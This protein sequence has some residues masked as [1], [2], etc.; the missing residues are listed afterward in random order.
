MKNSLELYNDILFLN[1]RPWKFD[2]Q[3]DAKFKQLL[4][5]TKKEYYSNQPNYEVDF[6]KPLSNLHKYY[7]A[8]IDH[9]AIRFLNI[10][11]SEISDSL[12]QQE[13]KYNIYVALSKILTPKL[14]EIAKIIKD[15]GYTPEQFDL[16]I[17][18]TSITINIANQSYILHYLK[19]Q[20]IRLFLEV[21]DSF[22]E[23]MNDDSLTMEEVYNSFFNEESPKRPYIIE[24]VDYPTTKKIISK[25]QEE[26]KPPFK[27][28]R[29]DI[30]EP[31]NDI[32]SYEQ[33]VSNPSRFAII[34][35]KLFKE[36]LINNNYEFINKHGQKQFMA[37]FYHQLVRKG[38]F[39]NRIFPDNI[40]AKPLFIRKFL[41]YRYS[42]NTDKQFRN[43]A[44]QN[45]ELLNFIEKDYWLENIDQC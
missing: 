18:N 40:E 4:L 2:K 44:K 31:K 14:N 42:T 24:A 43:W 37:A 25:K 32:F 26:S 6:V 3:S 7:H 20:I 34:E 41:D 1:L 9:E 27:A 45:T 12:N 38:Y 19:H 39:N 35:E 30:K 8:I 28:I 23:F 21:Q 11:H 15:R 29:G 17:K 10:L 13:K 22:N 16:S 5:E 36:G 33:L